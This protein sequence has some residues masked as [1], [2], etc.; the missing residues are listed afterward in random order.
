MTLINFLTS[1]G[2]CKK[3]IAWLPSIP[4]EMLGNMKQNQPLF[5]LSTR[6]KLVFS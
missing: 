3:Q 2:L 4:K 6:I 1:G 5:I